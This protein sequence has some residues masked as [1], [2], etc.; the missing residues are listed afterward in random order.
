M[1][2]VIHTMQPLLLIHIGRAGE[3]TA[4]HGE[5][6]VHVVAVRIRVVEEALRDLLALADVCVDGLGTLHHPCKSDDDLVLAVRPGGPPGRQRGRAGMRTH[7]KQGG[8]QYRTGRGETQ[9][10]SELGAAHEEG[11]EGAHLTPV[12][13]TQW[14]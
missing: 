3:P 11:R 2:D 10:F 6:E 4:Q 13:R 7:S 1:R 12:T 14:P 5:E 8:R 9:T